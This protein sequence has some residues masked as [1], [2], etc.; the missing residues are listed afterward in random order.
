LLAGAGAG[1]G[2]NFTGS[3]SATKAVTPDVTPPPPSG[4]ATLSGFVYLDSNKS[5][6]RDSGESGIS[7]ITITL[8]G[9]D[10]NGNAVN[11]T[12]VSGS[13]GSYSFT[14]LA[15]GTYQ[16]TEQLPSLYY[17]GTN[18]VGSVNG[19]ADGT[20]VGTDAIGSITLNSNNSGVEYDFAAIPPPV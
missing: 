17:K 3:Y 20:L 12:A 16:L 5:A 9:F 10:T 14:N 7:G 8:T 6:T 11:L 15:A 19:S 4:T 1:G 13:D 2:S 18:A